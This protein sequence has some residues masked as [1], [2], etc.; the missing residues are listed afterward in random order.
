MMVYDLPPSLPLLKHFN[1]WPLPSPLACLP[2]LHHSSFHYK[3][4]ASGSSSP[5][6]YELAEA[7]CHCSRNSSCGNRGGKH[8]HLS[9]TVLTF[10]AVLLVLAQPLPSPTWLP[11]WYK[12]HS[13]FIT[14]TLTWTSRAN[15]NKPLLIHPVMHALGVLPHPLDTPLHTLL[16]FFKDLWWIFWISVESLN[17]SS[18]SGGL[19]RGN[20][21]K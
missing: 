9:F 7:S 13:L 14:S 15:L 18:S 21:I 10:K 8:L 17:A 4:S 6:F 19:F 5:Y 1:W 16:Q 2:F 11:C 12:C 3:P 20:I